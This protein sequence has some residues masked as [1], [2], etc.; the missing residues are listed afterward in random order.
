MAARSLLS[1][2]YE[3]AAIPIY[4]TM[5]VAFGGAAFYL[6][7]LATSPD[8][9]YSREGASAYLNIERDANPRKFLVVYKEGFEKLRQSNA[10]SSNE[11][12]L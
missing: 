9:A 11:K 12:A 8:V 1:K 5:A 3:P 7:R 6:G 10:A 2:W 4:V